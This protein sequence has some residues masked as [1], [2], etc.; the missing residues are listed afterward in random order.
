MDYKWIYNLKPN[1]LNFLKL[2]ES[3]DNPGTVIFFL[4]ISFSAQILG[5]SKE[6]EHTEQ[7]A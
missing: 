2:M 7:I 6:V 4:G 1:I 3:K 5:L